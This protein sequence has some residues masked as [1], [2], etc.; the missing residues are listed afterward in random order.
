MARLA[1]PKTSLILGVREA[2]SISIECSSQN[3]LREGDLANPSQCQDV[4]RGADAVIM[5]AAAVGGF[6]QNQANPWIQITRNATVNLTVIQ[7]CVEL[8]IKRLVLLN[9]STMYQDFS[10][11]IKE[12]QLDRNIPSPGHYAGV[13]ET[14]RYIERCGL[15][16]N[17]TSSTEVVSLR[18]ANIYGPYARFAPERSNFI[19]A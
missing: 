10:G 1:P 19:P 14:F 9:S 3:E 16:A 18:L 17:D 13:G 12:S 2:P 15:L 11:N 7:A 4:L 8:G 6:K 5:S